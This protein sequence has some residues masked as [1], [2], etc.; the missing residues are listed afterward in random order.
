[1]HRNAS[2]AILASLTLLLAAPSSRAGL[3]AGGTASIVWLNAS[4]KA[5]VSRDDVS[6]TPTFGVVVRG[7]TSFRGADVQFQM[8]SATFSEVSP[9]WQWWT[10]GSSS[11]CA[12]GAQT[13][14]RGFASSG[15]GPAADS[16]Y[17]CW[18]GSGTLN[19]PGQV[20]LQAAVQ[21]HNAGPCLTPSPYD[22]VWMSSEGSGGATRAPQKAY[23]VFR[24]V[25]DQNF[26]CDGGCSNPSPMCSFVSYRQPCSDPQ[27]PRGAVVRVIDKNGNSDYL[28]L[29]TS[30][31]TWNWPPNFGFC[32]YSDAVRSSTWGRIRAAYR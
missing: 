32:P 9:S 5:N 4:N 11:G 24:L 12:S 2:C 18:G 27:N 16:I 25:V 7:V 14:T 23:G 3:N 1:M 15:S 8:R 6:C 30:H 26:G 17:N 28:P 31:L 29:L 20:D 10:D 21:Y 22:M 19:V 13:F